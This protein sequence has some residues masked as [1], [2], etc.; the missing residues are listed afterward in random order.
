MERHYLSNEVNTSLYYR[1]F[2]LNKDLYIANDGS[3]TG[4]SNVKRIIC[5][6]SFVSSAP[7]MSNPDLK[8][9]QMRNWLILDQLSTK[10][11]ENML[12][13]SMERKCS[14]YRSMSTM[15]IKLFVR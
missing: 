8:R 2:P 5:G 15:I 14:K 4:P 6:T 7:G 10:A 12:T 11:E 13:G 3:V 1:Y 9:N